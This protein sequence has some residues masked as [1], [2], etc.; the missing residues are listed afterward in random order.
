MLTLKQ[1]TLGEQILHVPN[2]EDEAGILGLPGIEKYMLRM[3][4]SLDPQDYAIM[5]ANTKNETEEMFDLYRAYGIPHIS[6]E[7]IQ[8]LDYSAKQTLSQAILEQRHQLKKFFQKTQLAQ[9]VFHPFIH[10]YESDQMAEQFQVTPTST[11]ASSEI[12]N[13]KYISQKALHER[14]VSTPLGQLVHSLSEAQ[15]FAEKLLANGYPEFSFKIIRSASGMG[16]FKITAEQLPEYF[17]KYSAEVEANGVLLDGWITASKKASP[18][19]QY[20]VSDTPAEDSF[21]SCSDQILEDLAHKGNINSPELL[22]NSPKLLS[23]CQEI[24]NWVRQQNYRGIIGI[25]FYITE[26]T[27]QGI[28]YYMETNARINGSTPGALLVDKLHGSTTQTHWGVQ[29]NIYVPENSTL[30]D[31]MGSLEKSKL[32]YQPDTR[33]GVLPTNTSAM[34]THNKAMVLVIGKTREHVR[35]MLDELYNFQDNKLT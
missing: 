30:S 22:T 2:I 33:L 21:I 29:N 16:V 14:G 26:E 24:R 25:D 7:N 15:K 11:A 32:A 13:N 3:L 6:L 1:K 12:V 4:S 9:A 8:Y 5:P 19:I 28:P 17:Q 18:N 31:F 10:S 34:A 23:D 27:E 35:E 20:Y